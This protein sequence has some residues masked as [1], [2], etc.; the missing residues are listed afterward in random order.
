MFRWVRCFN[1]RKGFNDSTW[2]VGAYKFSKNIFLL[3]SQ[4]IRPNHPEP[5]RVDEPDLW[6]WKSHKSPI[7]PRCTSSMQ[8]VRYNCLVQCSHFLKVTSSIRLKVFKFNVHS[9]LIFCFKNHLFYQVESTKYSGSMFSFL[10]VTS[11][12]R[13]FSMLRVL[14]FGHPSSACRWATD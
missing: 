6:K 3:V 7:L 2:T 4:I 1:L 5:W 8:R 10:K 13:L 14:R 12:I 9:I 11:S